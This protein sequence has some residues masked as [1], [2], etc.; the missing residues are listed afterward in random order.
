MH[1]VNL[2]ILCYLSK[3]YR[4]A[5]PVRIFSSGWVIFTWKCRC[6][7]RVRQLTGKL[8]F[9]ST[10]FFSVIV[11]YFSYPSRVFSAEHRKLTTCCVLMESQKM[12][13]YSS[14]EKTNISSGF[15]FGVWLNYSCRHVSQYSI[16]INV[17]WHSRN[18]Y[19][20]PHSFCDLLITVCILYHLHTNIHLLFVFLDIPDLG[21]IQ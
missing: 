3:I 11:F 2:T 7:T 18:V 1:T 6:F 13:L 15:F 20:I 9:S 4:E 16:I 5:I 10:V 12:G 8:L 14:W 19:L 17:S 21:N